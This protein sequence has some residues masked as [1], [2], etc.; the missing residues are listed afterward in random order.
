MSQRGAGD[1]GVAAGA[2]VGRRWAAYSGGMGV[3]SV[4]G[5][6]AQVSRLQSHQVGC[7]VGDGQWQQLVRGVPIKHGG[8]SGEEAV[9][10]CHGVCSV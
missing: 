8:G 7:V 3:A 10:V 6:V 1:R 5:R 2:K 9:L 4:P